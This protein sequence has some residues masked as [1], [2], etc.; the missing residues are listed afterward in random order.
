MFIAIMSVQRLLL[1]LHLS[2]NVCSNPCHPI[3]RIEV[4]DNVRGGVCLVWDGDEAGAG[5][6][7]W[8]AELYGRFVTKTLNLRNPGTYQVWTAA[9]NVLSNVVTVEVR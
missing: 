9:G 5:Q 6:T 8:Q 4:G 7:C 2:L 1:T 3:A